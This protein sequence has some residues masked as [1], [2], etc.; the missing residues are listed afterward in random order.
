MGISWSGGGRRKQQ[1]GFWPQLQLDLRS[2]DGGGGGG[3]DYVGVNDSNVYN[4]ERNDAINKNKIKN[5]ND[6]DNDIINNDNDNDND[7]DDQNLNTEKKNNSNK[8]K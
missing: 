6:N 1:R 4:V 5:C 7:N 2:C 8:N 3:D